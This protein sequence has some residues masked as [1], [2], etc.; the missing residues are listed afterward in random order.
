MQKT[1][2]G[3]VVSVYKVWWMRLNTK[4]FHMGAAEGAV[5]PHIVKV[6]Y[7]LDGREYTRRRW[8]LSRNRVPAKGDTVQL[9]YDDRKPEKVRIV[10]GTD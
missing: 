2:T 8:I 9:L 10:F 3:T 6:R 4:A 7:M 1:T 5:F